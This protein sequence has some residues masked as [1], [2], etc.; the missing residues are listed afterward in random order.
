VHYMDLAASAQAVVD[1]AM[2]RIAHT[3]MTTV[4][5]SH[6]CLAGGVAL[7]CVSNG[8]LSRRLPGLN[9]I[10]IQP[11]AGDAGGALGAALQVAHTEYGSKRHAQLGHS[12]GQKGSLLGP[13]FETDE[14]ERALIAARLTY[15]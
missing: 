13:R 14:V 5:S 8:K 12:D 11:A 4:G 10:W 6:L 9:G 15:H 7:N 3:A 2:L 1:E